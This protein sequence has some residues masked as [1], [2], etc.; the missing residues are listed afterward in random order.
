MRRKPL[1][2]ALLIFAVLLASVGSTISSQADDAVT[3]RYLY[4]VCPGIRNYLEFG[5]AGI[6]VFDMDAGHKF[7]RQIETP[8]SREMSP[9]N[10]KGVCACAATGRLYFTTRSKLFCLDLL[11]DRTLW[12]IEPP[13]GTDRMSITPGIELQN[14]WDSRQA[15]IDGSGNLSGIQNPAIDALIEKIVLAKSRKELVTA[16]RAIDRVLRAGYYWVPQ[17]SK[18]SHTIVYWDKFSRRP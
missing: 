14:L 6:L 8:A 13:N 4:V 12:E 5:G 16:A 10:I 2:S 17:W 9:D 15:N 18:A 1:R 7:I 11:T 3:K